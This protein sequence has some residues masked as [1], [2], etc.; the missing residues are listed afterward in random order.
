M[1]LKHG[2]GSFHRNGNERKGRD[3]DAVIVCHLN[4]AIVRSGSKN[5]R[6]ILFELNVTDA[7]V[8]APAEVEFVFFGTYVLSQNPNKIK[9]LCKDY[10]QI[11]KE[12]ERIPSYDPSQ[13]ETDNIRC[14][15]CMNRTTYEEFNRTVLR[16]ADDDAHVRRMKNHAVNNSL[17]LVKYVTYNRKTGLTKRLDKCNRSN[18]HSMC[19]RKDLKF[20]L[21]R[22]TTV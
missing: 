1:F 9:Q 14:H 10:N 2:S 20:H 12:F 13:K 18:Y 19:A 21:P 11:N 6:E 16:A 15:T 4:S 22:A 5:V 8:V 7:A 3:R 17:I